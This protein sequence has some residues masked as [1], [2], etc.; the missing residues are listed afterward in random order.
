MVLLNTPA[1]RSAFQGFLEFRKSYAVR[2][3]EPRLDTP[4]ENI[5]ALYQLWGTMALIQVVLECAAAAGYRVKTHS[6]MRRDSSGLCFRFL[7]DGE[8]VAVLVHP[9]SQVVLKL[10][11]ERTYKKAGALQSISFQQR[12]DIALEI[13]SPNAETRVLLFDPKYKLRSEESIVPSD[14]S[15]L[16]AS[17]GAPK[18]VDIDKMHAYRDAIRDSG[19]RRAVSYAAILYPGSEVRYA[20]DIEALRA[21]PGDLVSLTRRL[22]E[23]IDLA[24]RHVRAS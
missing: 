16:D 4:L 18:K 23:V 2:I 5:P 6:L 24:I 17:P 8:P 15:D 7:P 10:I 11:P 22:H 1:Y 20:D 14:D 3:N 19:L 9:E 13:E 12:P 21:Y